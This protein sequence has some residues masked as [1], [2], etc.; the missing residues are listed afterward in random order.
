M[1]DREA[2]RI[3][4]MDWKQDD[5]IPLHYV[6]DSAKNLFRRFR[7][8]LFITR[9]NR[10]SITIDESG[11]SE[12]PSLMITSR[13][14]TVGAGDSY[15]AGA[16]STLAA[17]YGVKIAAEIGT[18]V[19]GVTVQKL[20]QTGTASP[21]EI[22]K[23]GSDPDY[24]YSPDIA[25]DIRKAEYFNGSEIEIIHRRPVN[26]NIKYAI[27][28]HDGTIS[29]L[30]EGWEKVMAPMMIREILG[31]K[32]YDID[33]NIFRKVE[34]RVHEYIDATTGIQTISQMKG[35]CELILEF[36][37]VPEEKILDP[38]GY[39]KIY[40]AE[41]LRLVGERV[42]KLKKNEL[43]REDFMIKN[44]YA[45]IRAL[46]GFGI[47]LYLASGTDVEDVRRE[48][49]IL[50]YEDLFGNRIY[51]SEGNLDVEVKKL[52]LDRILNDIGE[53]ESET[54]VTFGDGPVEIRETRK[55]GG[56]TVGIASDEVRRFGLNEKKRTRLIK[57]GADFIVPDFT[58]SE[59][60]LN[61]LKII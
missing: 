43:S 20:F 60:L 29:T 42:N 56:I 47:K 8:P 6:V 26:Q 50:G 15:L 3:C 21:Q 55:R 7:K 27:F 38:A 33:E 37:F 39:K 48:A 5:N 22:L 12:L 54:I 4:G 53:S 24:I 41:L 16:S 19:A 2:L 30:R 52:V 57:A 49:A 58:Q 61:L 36:G 44:S 40:I 32:F 23:I 11:I 31:E 10:G 28:D 9:G 25:E 17:G 45:F 51:G 1:N 34:M 18:L 14:D 59:Q 13:I 46:H 35:L